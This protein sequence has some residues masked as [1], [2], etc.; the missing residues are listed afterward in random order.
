MKYLRKFSNLKIFYFYLNLFKTNGNFNV[1]M[2][3]LWDFDKHKIL[4]KI[5]E[6]SAKV[7]SA[8]SV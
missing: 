8:L 1:N 4:F 7:V 2:K 5:Y 6:K 3:N